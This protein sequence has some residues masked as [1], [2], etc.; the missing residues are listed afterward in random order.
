MPISHAFSVRI[1][2]SFSIQTDIKRVG[3]HKKI[4]WN[5]KAADLLSLFGKSTVD[6]VWTAGVSLKY[7]GCVKR[8]PLKV[9]SL[10]NLVLFQPRN[11]VYFLPVRLLFNRAV[12]VFTFWHILLR[13]TTQRHWTGRKA[14]LI[15]YLTLN[16]LSS[17]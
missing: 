13:V 14:V 7:R 8:E 15:S 12:N 1:I 17:N 10:Y 3:C 2:G 5:L 9:I 4:N 16:F 6:I 11:Q